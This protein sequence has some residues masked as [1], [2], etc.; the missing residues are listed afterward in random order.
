MSAWEDGPH[1]DQ[2]LDPHLDLLYN[3][4]MSRFVQM[5]KGYNLPNVLTPLGQNTFATIQTRTTARMSMGS[6]PCLKPSLRAIDM[7][8]PVDAILSKSGVSFFM[9]PAKGRNACRIT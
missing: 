7:F 6:C 5:Q 3:F 1:L 9:G 2:I 8:D 4:S